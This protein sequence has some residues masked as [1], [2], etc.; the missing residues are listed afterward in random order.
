M[1]EV[2]LTTFS[3]YEQKFLDVIVPRRG[4][5]A[6]HSVHPEGSQFEPELFSTNA[7]IR[8]D[9]EIFFRKVCYS[10]RMLGAPFYIFHGPVRLKKTEYE[11]DF[12]RLGDRVNQ[13]CEIA[14][15][16]GV[17]LAY[18][19][20]FYGYGNTPDYFKQLLRQCP[21]LLAVLDTRHALLAGI[22]PIKF[23]EAMEGKICTIHLCDIKKD[24][25]SALP[26]EG[27][28]NFEKFFN[29]ANKARVNASVILEPS[30]R[31]YKDVNQLK[32][33]YDY[34]NALIIRSRT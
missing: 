30:S 27:K 20:V 9:A 22:E 26:G 17:R 34:L 29:E 19:N 8:A 3:E 14:R 1:A 25:D 15:S 24:S 13:L 11:F 16:Y 10:A 28:Y 2:Y 31:D 33:C 32:T 23:L 7:R 12:V 5:I 4:N 21:N 18:E 6:V